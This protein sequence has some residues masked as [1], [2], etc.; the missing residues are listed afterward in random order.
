MNERPDRSIIVCTKNNEQ[1][2]E[3]ALKSILASLKNTR[4]RRYEI[5][6]IDGESEDNTLNVVKKKFNHLIK[7]GIMRIYSDKGKGIAFARDLGF[8]LAKGDYIAYCDGDRV[9]ELNWFNKMLSLISHGEKIGCVVDLSLV[10]GKRTISQMKNGFNVIVHTINKLIYKIYGT[11]GTVKCSNSIWRSSTLRSIGGFRFKFTRIGEDTDVC[12]RAL[13]KGWRI[14]IC[15]AVNYDYYELN[16][17][18]LMRRYM[19][20]GKVSAIFKKEL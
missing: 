2:I 10:Q 14:G 13:L 20:Q 3:I 4:I 19:E 18:E 7:K 5:L 17:K 1:S 15:D 9:L 11:V 8:R 16:S 6:I 12:F